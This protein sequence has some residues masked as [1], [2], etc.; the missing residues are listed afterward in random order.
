M[1]G[2]SNPPELEGFLPLLPPRLHQ[3]GSS[4]CHTQQAGS[5]TEAPV[6]THLRC[7]ESG[8]P[9]PDE[10]SGS[11]SSTLSTDNPVKSR[12][13]MEA[14]D[15]PVMQSDMKVGNPNADCPDPIASFPTSGQ[16]VSDSTLK[17]VLLS[18]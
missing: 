15:D 4:S 5:N 9:Y 12:P 1:P 8:Q 3:N 18:L 14:T 17:V 2:R 11:G 13:C 7:V 6:D 10:S 16:P